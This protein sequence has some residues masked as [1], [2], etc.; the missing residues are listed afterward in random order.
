LCEVEG[1][2]TFASDNFKRQLDTAYRKGY[3]VVV[4]LGRLDGVVL[5]IV[6]GKVLLALSW[7]ST[8]CP[9]LVFSRQQR[10]LRH[11]TLFKTSNL[12]SLPFTMPSE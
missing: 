6:D 3:R 12:E 9:V 7:E 2:S 11:V 1:N 4:D 8:T 10:G 5:P